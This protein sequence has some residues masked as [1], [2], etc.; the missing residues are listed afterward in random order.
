MNI[1]SNEYWGKRSGTTHPKMGR[2]FAGRR[3]AMS[4]DGNKGPTGW[5]AKRAPRNYANRKLKR[6]GLL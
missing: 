5:K 2:I 1:K 3:G 4:T 6:K